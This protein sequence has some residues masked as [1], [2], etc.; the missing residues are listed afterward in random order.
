MLRRAETGD[1]GEAA[2]APPPDVAGQS[3]VPALLDDLRDGLLINY[4]LL[5]IIIISSSLYLRDEGEAH[6][7]GGVHEHLIGHVADN[8]DVLGLRVALDHAADDVVDHV[9]LVETE[10]FVEGLA[11]VLHFHLVTKVLFVLSVGN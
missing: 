2:E 8:M 1:G 11:E 4:Q 7:A 10:R 6:P 3:V 5:L 9:A